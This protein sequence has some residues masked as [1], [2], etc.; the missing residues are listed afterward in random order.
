MK[1]FPL[2]KYKYY[3]YAREDGSIVV[4]AV[5]SFAG[6]RI[7]GRA[8]CS[9]NDHFDASIGQELAAARCNAKVAEKRFFR[10]CAKKN[11]ADEIVEIVKRRQKKM[12]AYVDDATDDVV[13]ALARVKE[14]ED[15]LI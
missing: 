2:N 10:A 11:E 7:K 1:D 9:P 15:K 3:S 8:I 13:A 12:A 4:V 5:S 6:R 14:L